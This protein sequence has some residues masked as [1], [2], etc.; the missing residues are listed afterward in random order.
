MTGEIRVTFQ[1]CFTADAASSVFSNNYVCRT[2]L[3]PYLY[4]LHPSC[5]D[6]D[7]NHCFRETKKTSARRV[8]KAKTVSMSVLQSGTRDHVMLFQLF[9]VR[10][11]LL[12]DV[13]G[14]LLLQQEHE[15]LGN[16]TEPVSIAV[17]VPVQI[18]AIPY[19][20]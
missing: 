9:P 1:G 16:T 7:N 8:K 15:F 19:P 2:T 20:S 12:A 4:T 17:V 3:L 5:N 14:G 13:A 6:K 11:I 10:L 18:L